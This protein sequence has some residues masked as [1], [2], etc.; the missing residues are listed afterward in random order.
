MVEELRVETEMCLH[1]LN[2]TKDEAK[3][4]KELRQDNDLFML[5]A[6]IGVAEV[7]LSRQDCISKA[8]DLLADGDT[9]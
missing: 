4:L 1:E 6:E 2:I 3:A 7:V 5:T 9:C 8:M